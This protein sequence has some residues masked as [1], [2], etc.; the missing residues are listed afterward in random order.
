MAIAGWILFGVAFL[1]GLLY[2]LGFRFGLTGRPAGSKSG[3]AGADE[4][5]G[6][7]RLISFVALLREPYALDE[8][9]LAHAVRKAL[10]AEVGT[11]E[12]EGPDGFVV[13]TPLTSIIQCRERTINVNAFPKPYV[14]E[15]EKTAESIV[16]LR[17][18]HAFLEHRAWLSCDALGIDP[19]ASEQELLSWY[20][21]LGKLLVELAPETRVALIVPDLG[22]IFPWNDEV[23]AAL[24][25]DTPVEALAD[26]LCPVV[27]IKD[28]DPRMLAAVAEARQRWPEFVTAFETRRGKNFSVKSPVTAADNTEF[29]WI[30]VTALENDVIYGTLGNEPIA[31]GNLRLG[32]RVRVPAGEL[33]DWVYLDQREE[34]VGGFTV[35]VL[36]EHARERGRDGEG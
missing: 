20:R 15:L 5:D 7:H 10:G 6:N 1:C 25:S 3:P 26:T 14:E 30:E 18:Q 2:M 28:D 19:N 17:C 8:V 24:V 31:L 16:D 32:S 9:L 11:G 29:I 23:E 36:A 13:V 4:P 12:I 33:N 34:M 21:D 35:R 27:S 22:R